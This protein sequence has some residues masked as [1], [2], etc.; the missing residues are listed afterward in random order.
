MAQVLFLWALFHFCSYLMQERTFVTIILSNLA[1]W[2]SQWTVM[3]VHHAVG[4]GVFSFV[5]PFMLSLL[6]IYCTDQQMHNL[7]I[8]I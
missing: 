8:Y 7:Y 1:A 2:Q 4:Y 3:T 5:L 6:Y